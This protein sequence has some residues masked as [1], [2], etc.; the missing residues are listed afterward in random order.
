MQVS[1]TGA[2]FPPKTCRTSSNASTRPTS[3]DSARA[4]GGTGLGL[5]ICQ[6][7]VAAHGGT[8]EIDSELGRG[9][10]VTVKLPSARI[11]GREEIGLPLKTIEV[12]AAT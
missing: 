7:I 2:A 10:T 9:T 12:P 3:R 6:S 4:R 1:D 5:S 11:A 8:I